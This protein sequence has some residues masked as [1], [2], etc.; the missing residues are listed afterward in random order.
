MTAIPSFTFQDLDPSHLDDK[1]DVA[2]SPFRQANDLDVDLDSVHEPSIIESLHDDMVDDAVEQGEAASD[3]MQDENQAPLPDDDM[4]DDEDPTLGGHNRDEDFNMDP[5]PEEARVDED[6]DILYEEE[7]DI[8]LVAEQVEEAVETTAQH[9]AQEFHEVEEEVILDDVEEEPDKQNQDDLATNQPAAEPAPGVSG[10]FD[11]A[12]QD[13]ANA[14][15]DAAENPGEAEAPSEA[16]D[17]GNSSLEQDKQTE[18]N[19]ASNSAEVSAEAQVD[20][21]SDEQHDSGHVEENAELAA[22]PQ[23]AAQDEN[24]PTPE[25]QQ[26]HDEAHGSTETQE[27]TSRAVHPVTLV[28]LEEE[29]SLFPPMIGDD[30]SMYFLAD[31]SLAFEPLD[32]LLAACREL[33]TGTLDHHDELVLDI[34]SLGLHICEDSKYASQITLA[35]ILDVYLQL[36]RNDVGQEIRPLYCYLSSRVSLA[37]Q[38]AYLVSSS[39]EGRTFSEVVADHV[40]TPEPEGESAEATDYKDEQEDYGH[41]EVPGA[42]QGDEDGSVTQAVTTEPEVDHQSG[43]GAAT[44]ERGDLEGTAAEATGE[45]IYASV[46]EEFPHD[47]VELGDLPEGSHQQGTEQDQ[48]EEAPTEEHAHRPEAS[49]GGQEVH[50]EDP[51]HLDPHEQETN[52]SHTVEAEV[53]EVDTTVV[54]GDDAELG[55]QQ[56]F[57][58]P[59]EEAEDLFEHDKGAEEANAEDFDAY[60]D[61][62]I[63]HQEATDQF[64]TDD[65]VVSREDV[66]PSTFEVTEEPHLATDDASHTVDGGTEPVS[67]GHRATS[68]AGTLEA[69]SPPVTPSKANPAKRKV[70]DDD[71]LDLLDLD[72]PEPKRRRPS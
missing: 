61:E 37:S 44:E 13:S 10:N 16:H 65:G 2:S 56:T 22:N 36:C 34:T 57:E 66:Q 60:G 70:E 49:P 29:M 32:K 1:M 6:E 41:Q 12:E 26:H 64:V 30:S 40:D 71:E 24:N 51:D 42:D 52:S 45:A 43:N 28:Y 27:T 68:P 11:N 25:T 53:A 33:L 63:L 21:T 14:H 23:T 8:D 18:D 19:V 47:P 7:E 62:E 50:P 20:D 55:A 39:Q 54:V 31:S 17:I 9:E 72:T 67:N 3:L 15:H 59:D 58:D 38:Y 69:H 35:Q 46:S 5:F 4:M 48:D